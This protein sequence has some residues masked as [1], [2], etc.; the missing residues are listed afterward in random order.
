MSMKCDS[1]LRSWCCVIAVIFDWNWKFP[2]WEDQI[3]GIYYNWNEIFEIN[4][5]FSRFILPF[6]KRLPLLLLLLLLQLIVLLCEHTQRAIESI[7]AMLVVK[8]VAVAARAQQQPR[9]EYG[10]WER[11]AR[12]KKYVK[13]SKTYCQTEASAMSLANRKK[14]EE[15][16]HKIY[17]QCECANNFKSKGIHMLWDCFI[18]STVFA[19]VFL[20][21]ILLLLFLCVHQ[22]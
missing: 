17:S 16:K 9:A 2:M 19:W 15:R 13:H 4:V 5:I 6:F 11:K 12:K 7:T 22:L 21:L 10:C 18:C 14:W 20:L 1:L 8:V 3:D